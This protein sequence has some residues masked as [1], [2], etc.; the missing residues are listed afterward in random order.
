VWCD[1]AARTLEGL[2]EVLGFRAYTVDSGKVGVMT[3]VVTL[4]DIV[5]EAKEITVVEDP[6]LDVTYVDDEGRPLDYYGLLSL[7]S[8]GEH[9]RIAILQGE[10]AAPDFLMHP[11]DDRQ[12]YDHLVPQEADSGKVL[13]SGL[14]KYRSYLTLSSF[15][16]KFGTEIENFLAEEGLPRECLYLFLYPLGGDPAIVRKARAQ[17]GVSKR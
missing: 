2:Y 4:V 10:G 12:T 9:D 16:A 3:H 15:E 13:G 14:V 1:G 11:D 6:S 8:R 5:Y 7:L 17:I